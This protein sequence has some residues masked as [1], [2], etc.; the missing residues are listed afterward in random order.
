VCRGVD[1]AP[2]RAGCVRRK[3][4]HVAG[5]VADPAELAPV[6]IYLGTQ[7]ADPVEQP[8]RPACRKTHLEVAALALLL[9]I[10]AA[11]PRHEM[12]S[13]ACTNRRRL[14]SCC[15]TVSRRTLR[16]PGIAVANSLM[17]PPE[18]A[19]RHARISLC[20]SSRIELAHRTPKAS[21][22]PA[23][24]RRPRTRDIARRGCTAAAWRPAECPVAW[25]PAPAPRASR[26]PDLPRCA[27]AARAWTGSRPGADGPGCRPTSR[28][29]SPWFGSSRQYLPC[30]I[31]VVSGKFGAPRKRHSRQAEVA[32]SLAKR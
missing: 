15:R 13:D 9:V 4:S 23:R 29:S 16:G 22:S 12:P 14:M 11:G 28:F 3:L 1:P 32:S 6:L 5:L 7:H 8:A 21:P 30:S 20:G 17:S 2:P 27:V 26:P 31:Y 10:L 18:R 24:R 19:P 25:T